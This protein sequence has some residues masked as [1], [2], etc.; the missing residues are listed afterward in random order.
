MTAQHDVE[1]QHCRGPASPVAPARGALRGLPA[2]DSWFWLVTSA[3]VEAIVLGALVLLHG[4]PR[5][6]GALGAEVIGHG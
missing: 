4:L 6:L 2:A 5:L 1:R 3:A